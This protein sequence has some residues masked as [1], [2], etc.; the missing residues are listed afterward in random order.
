MT[1]NLK[2][3]AFAAIIASMFSCRKAQDSTYVAVNEVLMTE[4]SGV[5]Y[6]GEQKQLSATVLP[7]N[8]TNKDLVWLSMDETVATVD[9][10]GYVT[11]LS[12]GS[13]TI[14]AICV[15]GRKTAEFALVVLNYGDEDGQIDGDIEPFN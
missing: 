7:E 14:K 15:D 1:K 8:A 3:I 2:Y 11:T 10:N 12:I 6:V 5:V 13:A 9:Q 4:Q